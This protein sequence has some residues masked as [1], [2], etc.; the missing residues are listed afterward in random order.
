MQEFMPKRCD[1]PGG[2][3]DSVAEQI[4]RPVID[5][6]GSGFRIGSSCAGKI[7]LTIENPDGRLVRKLAQVILDKLV[8]NAS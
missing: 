7:D 1:R 2:V 5:A 8:K 3:S 6:T 4:D